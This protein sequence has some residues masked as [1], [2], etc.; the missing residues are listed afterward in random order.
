[1][2]IID[3]L[4]KLAIQSGYNESDWYKSYIDIIPNYVLNQNSDPF[5]KIQINTEKTMKYIKHIDAE[6]IQG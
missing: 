5:P 4:K 2:V 3:F 6:L 1:M